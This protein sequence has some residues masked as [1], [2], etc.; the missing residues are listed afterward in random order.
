MIRCLT[1]LTRHDLNINSNA[2]LNIQ[3]FRGPVSNKNSPQITS[4]FHFRS[5]ASSYFMYCKDFVINFDQKIAQN[6]NLLFGRGTSVLT[7]LV[8][9]RQEASYQLGELATEKFVLEGRNHQK[10][11]WPCNQP[12]TCFVHGE[13]RDYKI[14][15]RFITRDFP[16]FSTPAA[17]QQEFCQKRSIAVYLMQQNNISSA[18]KGNMIYHLQNLQL[19]N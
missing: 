7:Y 1:R 10:N 5:V 17:A 19:F 2:C 15:L 14:N 18:K 13:Q 6:H 11:K 16:L 3:P 8:L 12:K 4:V 9:V